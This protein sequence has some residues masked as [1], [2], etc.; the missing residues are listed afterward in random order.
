MFLKC[1]IIIQE[2]AEMA[3]WSKYPPIKKQFYVEHVEVAALTEEEV[4]LFREENNNIVVDR[5]F[6]NKDSSP[7][8]KPC[9]KFFHAF[10]NYPEI[11]SE[12]EKAG[13]QTP[14]PI[15]TQAWP[16]LLSGEDLIGIA[17]TGT[18]KYLQ[19]YPDTS[20]IA[21]LDEI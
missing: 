15:Q 8:P 21:V 20:K 5:T 13:F 9:P 10:F 4:Q 1:K 17:Q 14:T 18:G 2:E 11:L 19:Q 3:E 7:I 12:I 16:V 6:K